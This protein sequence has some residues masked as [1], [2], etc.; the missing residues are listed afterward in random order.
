MGFGGVQPLRD[1]GERRHAFPVRTILREPPVGA[2]LAVLQAGIPSHSAARR[3]GPTGAAVLFLKF[4]LQPRE[5]LR[6]DHGR[7][8]GTDRAL[9][10]RHMAPAAGSVDFPGPDSWV[11]S[12]SVAVRYRHA[13]VHTYSGRKCISRR[14]VPPRRSTYI[15]SL[16]LPPPLRPLPRRC[17]RP[18]TLHPRRHE[19]RPPQSVIALFGS[20][21]TRATY[22]CLVA[23]GA[24][25]ERCGSLRAA[26]V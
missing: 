21:D 18:I 4:R 15:F 25:R 3:T 17:L 16:P 7:G 11:G 26:W 5:R 24:R 13:G 14:P 9:A 2:D 22:V 12:A 20:W 6:K 23:R 1:N 10:R 8:D 19:T